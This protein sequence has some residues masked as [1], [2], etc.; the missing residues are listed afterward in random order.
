MLHACDEFLFKYS[1]VETAK[2]WATQRQLFWKL[3]AQKKLMASR[4]E[5]CRLSMVAIHRCKP[6]SLQQIQQI[7]NLGSIIW[8]F[9]I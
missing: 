5:E 2:L 4:K 3:I 1:H 8:P 6:V 7:P 9:F